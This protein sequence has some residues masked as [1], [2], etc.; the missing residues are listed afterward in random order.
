MFKVYIAVALCALLA[1]FFIIGLGAG[2]AIQVI[3]LWA[4]TK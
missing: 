3:W 4:T 2:K 1:P